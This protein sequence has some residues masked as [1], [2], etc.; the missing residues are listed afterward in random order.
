[1][2]LTPY[3]YHSGLKWSLL[4][5]NIIDTV[6]TT[7]I[8][9]TMGDE[10]V[11][12]TESFTTS[13][14]GN[15]PV[16]NSVAPTYIRT[17]WNKGST[18]ATK[19]FTYAK[20]RTEALIATGT[21]KITTEKPVAGIPN[22]ELVF[23]GTSSVITR[24]ESSFDDYPTLEQLR[25]N[26][27]SLAEWIESNK[28]SASQA[29]TW[30]YGTRAFSMNPWVKN[31]ITVN[32]PQAVSPADIYTNW[33]EHVTT[34]TTAEVNNWEEH[35]NYNPGNINAVRAKPYLI[36]GDLFEEAQRA[37]L[38]IDNS[39]S[40]SVE[41]VKIDD[42]NFEITWEAP[43]RFAYIAASQKRGTILGTATDI[44]NW[45]FIDNITQIDVNIKSQPF[46][47]D[48]VTRSYS[49]SASNTLTTN[50]SNEH[51]ITING[52][53]VIT[54]ETYVGVGRDPWTE[55]IASTLLL[56]YK[57][58][59]YIV[60]CTVLGDW[61][62]QNNIHINSAL[63]VQLLDGT[64]ISRNGVPCFFEVKTIEKVYRG[65]TFE[66][67]LGLLESYTANKLATP[68]GL[69]ITATLDATQL[70]K[71]TGLTITANFERE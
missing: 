37:L 13:S 2:T 41:I 54:L 53:E 24:G 55:Y 29:L 33:A 68:T 27:F 51:P 52:D 62:M 14:L 58:G 10:T 66:F 61:A 39:I 46:N 45:A 30:S 50:I 15:L 28:S 12:H 67:N 5:K 40:I 7:P 19:N 32:D 3:I 42:Y 35:F 6:V 48:K 17:M 71:P 43:V 8:N 34:S 38:L 4:P 56:K 44:D 11:V 47:T 22:V 23:S 16:A 18:F 26:T 31:I 63:T 70:S 69:T 57:E 1:M 21:K 60:N 25:D 49:L 59:K 36:G 64:V 65:D 20:A 9:N